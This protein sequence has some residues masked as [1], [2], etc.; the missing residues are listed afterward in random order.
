MVDAL[1]AR[2]AKDAE[3]AVQWALAE[4]KSL[5]IVGR[6][7]KRTLGR[8]AQSEAARELPP[9]EE[10]QNAQALRAGHSSCD[11]SMATERGPTR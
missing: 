10:L 11:Q 8:P 3:A 6:G 5:E 7:T 1:K 2:D 9:L 4:N